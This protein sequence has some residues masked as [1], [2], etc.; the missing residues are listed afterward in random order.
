MQEISWLARCTTPFITS[1]YMA[2]MQGND[3]W[4]CMEYANV[5]SVARVLS[6]DGVGKAKKSDDEDFFIFNFIFFL[7][8]TDRTNYCEY[9]V[10]SCESFGI[11]PQKSLSP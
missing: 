10:S 9:F 5:G 2:H 1:F 3:L 7:N 11:S 8:R 6:Q 4:I